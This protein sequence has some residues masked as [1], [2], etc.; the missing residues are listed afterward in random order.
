MLTEHNSARNDG[1]VRT[2]IWVVV[3]VLLVKVILLGQADLLPEEAYYW[4]YAQHLDMGYLDHPPFVAWL[5]WLSTLAFGNT[6]F[7]VRLPAFLSWM[8]LAVCMF[9]LARDVLG[10][11]AA[12]GCL[13]LLA[14]LPIYWSVGFILTPNAPL[15]PA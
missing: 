6:E 8:V 11:E 15:Y 5:V 4:N 13:I 1:P 10:R 2:A 7:G 14:V 9:R 12:Y 3:L